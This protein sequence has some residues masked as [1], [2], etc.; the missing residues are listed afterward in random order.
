MLG[1]TVGFRRCGLTGGWYHWRIA[2]QLSKVSCHPRSL[3]LL[4]ACGLRCG[5]S[6]VP[7]AVPAA[8]IP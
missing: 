2:V 3:S 4:P 1:R 8:T 5:L 6:A 7:A